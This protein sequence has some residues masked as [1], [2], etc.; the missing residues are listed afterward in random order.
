MGAQSD[1]QVDDFQGATVS[2]QDWQVLLNWLTSDRGRGQHQALWN[3]NVN[4]DKSPIFWWWNNWETV[5]CGG[6]STLT[7]LFWDCDLDRW[8][9]LYFARETLCLCFVSPFP[10]RLSPLRLFSF[11]QQS[12]GCHL[13][14]S[15]WGKRIWKICARAVKST[16]KLAYSEAM[17]TAGTARLTRSMKQREDLGGGAELEWWVWVEDR[18]E[19]NLEKRSIVRVYPTETTGGHKIQCVPFIVAGL[20]HVLQA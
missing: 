18:E 13:L 5:L 4:A 19:R 6:F 7:S 11:R 2:F 20:S 3:K 1:R 10:L 8:W 9:A 12:R 14:M 15:D 16:D 17:F